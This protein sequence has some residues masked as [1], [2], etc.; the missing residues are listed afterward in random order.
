MK[1]RRFLV[2]TALGA[3]AAFLGSCG[4]SDGPPDYRYRLKVEVNTPEGVKT[5]SSVIQVTQRL[6][7]PGSNPAGTAVERSLKG[8]AVAIDLPGG[9][10]L[11]A[12]L[13]SDND[14]GW[15]YR[16]MQTL[17]PDVEGESF[18]QQLDDMLALKGEI[19]LPRMFPR[20]G[21]IDERSAYPM[22]VIFGDINDPTSVKLVDPDDLAAI[23]GEG[24]S[25][26]RITVQIT[27]DPVTTGIVQRLVWLPAFYDKML[28]G[29]KI[30]T[31]YA[32]N[33][34]A[35]DLYQGDFSKGIIQ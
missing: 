28:D 4:S 5:G 34:F 19:T 17:A 13:R 23:F 32:K 18:E 14:I 31:I 6:V 15:A 20:H 30:N 24:V 3:A 21:P 22:L 12:L 2:V 10:T 25:L 27:E 26:K 7:R 9:K 8:E 1:R 11:F 33:R 29:Q 16:V 35:N